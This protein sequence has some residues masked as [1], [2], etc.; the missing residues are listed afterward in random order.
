MSFPTQQL[1]STRIH[2]VLSRNI[3]TTIPFFHIDLVTVS[4]RLPL[5]TKEFGGTELLYSPND[6]FVRMLFFLMLFFESKFKHK[7]LDDEKISG[8]LV[9][10]EF[11]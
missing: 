4:S 1:V 3:L 10:G 6:R 9:D 7:L 8:K 11:A 2:D 5:S